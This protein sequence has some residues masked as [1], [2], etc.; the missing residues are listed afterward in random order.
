MGIIKA[1]KNFRWGYLFLSFFLCL[2]GA[3]VI[4]FKSETLKIVSYII[5]ASTLI[6]GLVQIVKLLS[7]RKRGVGFTFSIILTVLTL[8]CG[9]VAFVIPDK[10]VEIYP[11]FIGLIIIIDG[12]FKLQTVINAKRYN[13]KMWWFLLI[14][15]GATILFGFFAVRL[16]VGEVGASLFSIILGLALIFSGLENFFSL[17]YL[18]KIVKMA[19]TENDS[20]VKDVTDSAVIVDSYI[21]TDTKKIKPEIIAPEIP[22]IDAT[23]VTKTDTVVVVD[24]VKTKEDN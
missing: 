10:V 20:Y 21:D 14:F 3:L 4:L 18:G 17:F 19:K 6:V 9:L 24:V 22:L 5:A 8:V 7:D 11:M 23:D 12:A 16:R 1:I 15:S 2:A 13:L